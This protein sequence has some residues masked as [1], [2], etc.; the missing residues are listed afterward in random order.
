[1]LS[2]NLA[3]DLPR[4][5]LRRVEP[6]V[7]ALVLSFDLVEWASFYCAYVLAIHAAAKLSSTDRKI[8]RKIVKAAESNAVLFTCIVRVAALQ[9][10]IG[11]YKG[12]CDVPVLYTI[13][14]R[15]LALLT[16]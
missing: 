15:S 13:C 16:L 9:A 7:P 6:F 3:I 1:M 8:N 2:S 10:P 12:I 4:K 11:L 14:T 5:V